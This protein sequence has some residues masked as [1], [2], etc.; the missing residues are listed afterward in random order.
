MPA[1]PGTTDADRVGDASRSDL[2]DPCHHRID[3]EAELRDDLPVERVARQVLRLGLE[4]LPQHIVG[5]GWMPFRIPADA[6]VLDA[7]GLEES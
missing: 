6:D 5:D 2:V 1:G 3:V 7:V 4:S